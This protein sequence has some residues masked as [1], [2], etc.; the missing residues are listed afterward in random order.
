VHGSGFKTI[1]PTVVDPIYLSIFS[2]RFM[3]IA[4]QMGRYKQ[5]DKAVVMKIL[6]I[7]HG[8]YNYYCVIFGT[9]V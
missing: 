9:H 6:C 4:E 8:A 2:H 7:C 3:G 5:R 1:S